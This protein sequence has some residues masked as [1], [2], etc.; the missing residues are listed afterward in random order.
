M[1]VASGNFTIRALTV[2]DRVQW[3]QKF[4]AYADFYQVPLEKEA[5]ESVWGWIFDEHNDFWCAVAEGDSG[6]I[7]GFTQYQLMHRSLSG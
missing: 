1:S 6:N 7:T 5:A 3:E 2:N 4:A